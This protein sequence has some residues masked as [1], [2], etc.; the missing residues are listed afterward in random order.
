MVVVLLPAGNRQ[1]VCGVYP[2]QNT[3]V[4]N[5]NKSS[6]KR[7]DCRGPK[8]SS[9]QA[10]H[11]VNVRRQFVMSYLRKATQP[12][13]LLHTVRRIC[14]QMG[15]I[16]VTIRHQWCQTVWHLNDEYTPWFHGGFNQLDQLHRI[17]QL[18]MLKHVQEQN[19]V[20]GSLC[21]HQAVDGI[22]DGHI[23]QPK[24]PGRIF[25]LFATDIYSPHIAI[26]ELLK[27][28]DVAPI[29]TSDLQNAGI[30]VFWQ[31]PAD[32]CNKIAHAPFRQSG[33]ILPRK[34]G[35]GCVIAIWIKFHGVCF[36]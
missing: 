17:I 15:D 30:F 28:L 18:E 19:H 33:F 5:Q 20:V 10:R 32:M 2:A 6:D 9:D 14:P 24:Y 34:V 27:C 8:D 7:F 35:Y 21:I 25:D 16:P 13:M 11:A 29:A 12:E 4:G 1:H 26:S 22:L 3:A 31:M 23:A 36:P